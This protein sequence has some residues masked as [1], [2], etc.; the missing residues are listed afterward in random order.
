MILPVVC[1]NIVI[2]STAATAT[3]VGLVRGFK[4]SNIQNLEIVEGPKEFLVPV[5]P[6]A[7]SESN[8]NLEN[9]IP[10]T[11]PTDLDYMVYGKLYLMKMKAMK[12]EGF[13]QYQGNSGT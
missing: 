10:L 4:P 9:P 1:F 3:P 6:L 7:I 11:K 2:F 5:V 13:S 8:T 12:S